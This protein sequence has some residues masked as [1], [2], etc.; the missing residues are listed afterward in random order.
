MAPYGP[1]CEKTCIQGLQTSKTQTRLRISTFVIR[2][3][4]SI[5]CK[6]SAT[7]EIPIF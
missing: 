5:I 2:F 6:L 7:S 3:L 4:E 1:G